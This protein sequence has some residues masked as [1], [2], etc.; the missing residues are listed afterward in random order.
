MRPA[1]VVALV[2]GSILGI[3]SL[4]LVLGGA[5]LMWAHATQR[6]SGGYYNAP[7][8]WLETDSYAITSGK[9]DLGT[10]Q[11]EGEWNPLDHVGTVRLRMER[12]DG[13][14]IFVGIARRADVDGY[15]RSV[16]HDEV[17][18][19][20][21]TPRYRRTGGEARPADP[22]GQEFWVAS[23]VGAGL[24]TLSWDLEEGEWAAVVMN[25]D[26]SPGLRV[27]ADAAIRTG[28][29]L[30]IGGGLLAAGLVAAALALA[31]ILFASRKDGGVPVG[32]PAPAPAAA[33]TTAPV[34][35][36]APRAYPLRL[37]GHLDPDVNRWLWLVKWFLAIP[38][39]IVLFL[40]WTAMAVLTAVAG[41]AI[42]FTGRYPRALFDFNVG[43]L[44]WTWRVTFYAFT[45]GTDRYPPFS[46]EPDPDY[47]AH[48]DVAYPAALSRPLVLVKWWLLALPH[49]LV[50]GVFGG[51]LTWWAW[52]GTA[53]GGGGIALRG[54]LIGLLVLIAAVVL[55]FTG[56]YPQT[57]FDFVMGMERWTFRVVAYAGLMTDEYPPFRL[58][59][60]G[61]DSGAAETG[62]PVRG[63]PEP[64]LAPV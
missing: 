47:P 41:A 54:G 22:A 39:F 5:G 16:A 32:V 3:A 13:G 2:V 29:L 28:W 4:G 8:E 12:A 45:L 20:D 26:A 27:E 48:L 14:E 9:V 40:L 58:D 33:A 6:D 53:D 31:L 60:G 7:A 21:A 55:L 43:V 10:D 11:G 17:V 44:R 38:H 46:L 19:I 63:S 49:Y 62:T 64:G 42:L 24:Q 35:S 56:R 15:L 50:V 18:E 36:G 1:R 61:D 25:A 30:P 52:E 51:G 37:D 23:A 59:S 57:L 34:P